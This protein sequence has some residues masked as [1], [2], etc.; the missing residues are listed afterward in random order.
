MIR[1][2]YLSK[3]F[4]ESGEGDKRVVKEMNSS[5]VYLIHCKNFCKGYYIPPP[6]TTIKRI[7]KKQNR[8]KKHKYTFFVPSSVLRLCL[9][10]MYILNIPQ[11]FLK[12]RLTSTT[13]E[14]KKEKE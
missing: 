2:E 3:L 10:Y 12:Q 7:L 5:M 8:N 6:S 11:I 4:Q 14:K 13:K 9:L 1:I